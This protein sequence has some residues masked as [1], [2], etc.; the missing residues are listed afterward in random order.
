MWPSLSKDTLHRLHNMLREQPNLTAQHKDLLANHFC[1]ERR[2]VENFINWRFWYLHPEGGIPPQD[3]SLRERRHLPPIVTDYDVMDVDEVS[4]PRAH[5]PTPAASISPEPL[6]RDTAFFRAQVF[7]TVETSRPTLLRGDLSPPPHSAGSTS[8]T[9]ES[10]SGARPPPPLHIT[11]SPP[12][13]PVARTNPLPARTHLPSPPPHE[14]AFRASAKPTAKKAPPPSPSSAYHPYANARPPPPD[15]AAARPPASASASEPP[16]V[17]RTLREFEDAYSETCA[18]IGLFLQSV[19]RG[20]W[21]GRSLR[22]PITAN[23]KYL[24][25]EWNNHCGCPINYKHVGLNKGPP[26]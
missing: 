19:E 22:I 12:S 24:F 17:P 13:S 21:R 16:P 1:V 2:H 15:A 4:E 9:I 23:G 25:A 10:R 3:D 20:R 6:H 7:P 14:G 18:R 26:G 8:S 5:L 11:S